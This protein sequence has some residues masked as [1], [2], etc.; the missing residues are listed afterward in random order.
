[1]EGR[2]L[3]G[4]DR[5]LNRYD[6]HPLV[7][8]VAWSGISAATWVILCDRVRGH[9]TSIKPPSEQE[10]N[11][12]HDLA[13]GIELY[14]ALVRLEHYDE[15]FN[16][17][18][19][20]LSRP[21]LYRVGLG[22]LRTD[23]LE[24][25]FDHDSNP[26]LA[27]GF[28][29]AG[30]IN[31][32]AQS[33]QMVGRLDRAIE[34]FRAETR[35]GW[36]HIHDVHITLTSY[37]NIAFVLQLR[38]ML[39]RAEVAATWAVAIATLHRQLSAQDAQ[40]GEAQGLRFLGY[41][42]GATGQ[43]EKAKR[44]LLRSARLHEGLGARQSVGVDIAF[45]AEVALLAG[46]IQTAQTLSNQSWALAEIQR[47]ERDFIRCARL[48]AVAATRLDQLDVAEERLQYALRR[49]RAWGLTEEEVPVLIG[50]ADLMWRR[51]EF[52]DALALL[53]DARESIERGPYR[54][55]NSD[56]FLVSARIEHQRGNSDAA[57]QAALSAYNEAWCDGPPYVY[58]WALEESRQLLVALVCGSAHWPPQFQ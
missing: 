55:Y 5:R 42:W 37:G 26:L 38:G 8:G 32:L 21:T 44:A 3:V 48:Q 20:R 53:S 13:P 15:A 22:W 11:T 16:I 43:H 23:L 31:A 28:A 41:L 33:Y 50:M 7:K 51:N 45:Q 49:A 52:N 14:H 12:V 24:M 25:L 34:L 54:L 58:A 46:E 36:D 27:S 35:L 4:W 57:I 30:A 9:F 18:R 19:H 1:M 56:A 47:N 40:F 17:F 29:A 10:V 6:M 2:G 39:R